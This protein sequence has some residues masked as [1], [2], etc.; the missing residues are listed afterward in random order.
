MTPIFSAYP[1]HKICLQMEMFDKL[2]LLVELVQRHHINLELT[3]LQQ[4]FFYKSNFKHL[5]HYDEIIPHSAELNKKFPY[6]NGP[7]ICVVLLEHADAESY[8]EY[9]LL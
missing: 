5:F 4:I 3:T 9:V 7:K 2:D 6:K 1:K 8:S